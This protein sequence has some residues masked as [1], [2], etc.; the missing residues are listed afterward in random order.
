[1]IGNAKSFPRV[2]VVIPLYNKREYIVRALESVS[3]Q[4]FADFEAFVVDD[5]STDGSGSLASEFIVRDRRFRLITKKNGGVSSARNRGIAE[6]RGEFVCF[7]DADDEWDVGHLDNI[8]A[9]ADEFPDAAML[10]DQCV[11]KKGTELRFDPWFMSNGHSTTGIL[12]SYPK[13]LMASPNVINSSNACIRRSI[14]P[15]DAFVE[16][17]AIGEDLDLWLRIALHHQ[18]AYN[19]AVGAYYYRDTAQ[20]ARTLNAVHYPRGYFETINSALGDS[21]ISSSDKVALCHV[22][23]RKMVAYIFSLINAGDEAK[24]REKLDEWEPESSY[25]SFKLP[26]RISS[27]LPKFFVHAVSALRTRLL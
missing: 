14:L 22:R 10:F 1:M 7:L 15:N 3:S 8:I 13:T 4:E 17:D 2:S 27:F 6:S 11:V 18:V 26:L 19:A 25:A 23:D 21:R 12:A 24:A 16:G 20:N 9:L 5:G